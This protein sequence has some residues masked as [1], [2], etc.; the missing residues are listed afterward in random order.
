M[1]GCQSFSNRVSIDLIKAVIT[2]LHVYHIEKCIH[3]NLDVG[4]VDSLIARQG[5][6]SGCYKALNG[7]K[8][9]VN[10]MIKATMLVLFCLL[11]LFIRRQDHK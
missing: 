7:K 9:S 5:I 8:K 11:I 3:S 4:P 6:L 2:I 10:S 1:L